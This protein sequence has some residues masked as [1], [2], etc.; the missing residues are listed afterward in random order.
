MGQ[1]QVDQ[2]THLQ[3]VLFSGHQLTHQPIYF[4]FFLNKKNHKLLDLVKKKN[5]LKKE[6]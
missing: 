1:L 3:P 4:F 5:A 2:P 6:E